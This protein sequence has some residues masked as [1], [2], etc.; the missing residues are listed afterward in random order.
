MKTIKI[1]CFT[2]VLFLFFNCENDYN[3]NQLVITIDAV[4]QKTDSIN[5]YYTRSNSIDF[6][7]TQSFWIKV[8]GNKKNQNIQI[9]FPDSILPKQIRLDFGRNISQNDVVLNKMDFNYKNNSF[10]VKGKEIFYIL[11]VDASNTIVDKLNGSIRRKTPKQIKGPSLYPQG[12]KLFNR[13]NEL[14]SEK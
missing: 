4:I 13:L 6:T 10:S 7:D 1:M 9:I 11:R 12:D 3:T 14:Y 8:T 5:V 2:A